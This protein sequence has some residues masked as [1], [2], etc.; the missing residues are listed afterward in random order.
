MKVTSVSVKAR[1]TAWISV[2][3]WFGNI[4]ELNAFNEIRLVRQL[5]GGKSKLSESQWMTDV[6]HPSAFDISSQRV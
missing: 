5:A 4:E 2:R 6:I 1:S 3:G